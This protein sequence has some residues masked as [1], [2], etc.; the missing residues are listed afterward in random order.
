VIFPS[1]TAPRRYLPAP[2]P[3]DLLRVARL[4]SHHAPVVWNSPADQE[5][6]RG[7]AKADDNHL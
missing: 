7:G 3:P 1:Q 5:A 6:D 2:P 4:N